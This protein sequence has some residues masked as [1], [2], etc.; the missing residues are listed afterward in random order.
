MQKKSLAIFVALALSASFGAQAAGVTNAMLESAGKDS[1]SVLN[2]GISQDGQRFSPL[3]QVTT[4][5]VSKLV[6][7][8]SFSFGGE[9][10]RGQ[11]SQPLIYNGKMF[12]TAS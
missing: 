11:E 3:T 5:N 4:K 12:V 8:W 2:W 7:A 1:A 9:K 10:Q 6:P